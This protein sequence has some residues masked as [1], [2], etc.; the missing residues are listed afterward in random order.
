LKILGRRDC[1]ALQEF[2]SGVCTLNG[3]KVLDFK[4]CK[5]LRTTHE[6]FGV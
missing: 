6:V 2:P 3:L 4:G 5:I 1:E